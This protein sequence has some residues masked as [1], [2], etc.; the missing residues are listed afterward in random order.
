[1]STTKRLLAVN[2]RHTAKS[3]LPC[4]TELDTGRH[5]F[6]VGV[7]NLPS[8]F[9]IAIPHNESPAAGATPDTGEEAA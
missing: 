4:V 9:L 7:G 6:N 8:E 2:P 1:L 5:S 3:N